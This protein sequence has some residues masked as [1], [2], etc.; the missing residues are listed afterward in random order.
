MRICI[1]CGLGSLVLVAAAAQGHERVGLSP[2]APPPQPPGTLQ[3]CWARG[4]LAEPQP[5]RKDSRDVQLPQLKREGQRGGGGSSGLLQNFLRSARRPQKRAG[6]GVPRGTS[7]PTSGAPGPWGEAGE[8]LV[9]SPACSPAK[10]PPGEALL[11]LVLPCNVS[12]RE[13]G[14]WLELE[15]GRRSGPEAL[16]GS[17]DVRGLVPSHPPFSSCFSL[18][19]GFVGANPAAWGLSPRGWGRTEV[20]G[21]YKR[22]RL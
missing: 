21:G 4:G 8:A 19:V 7:S 14:R 16:S 20:A 18:S 11:R 22:H 3:P 13:A 1:I 15:G 10:N 17:D 5:P 2:L 9:L 12:R 6:Q